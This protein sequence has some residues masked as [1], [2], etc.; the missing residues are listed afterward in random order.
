MA[1]W[2]TGANTT[3]LSRN[4]IWV[5]HKIINDFRKFNITASAMYAV[6]PF[7]ILNIVWEIFYWNCC[8]VGVFL[9]WQSTYCVCLFL[10]CFCFFFVNQKSIQD[11]HHRKKS[12]KSDPIGKCTQWFFS[13]RLQ[14]VHEIQYSCHRMTFVFNISCS[15][16][17]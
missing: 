12:L 6:W 2:I 17:T 7:E 10:V 1:S 5:I 9:V 8:F 15:G 14:F 13:Q 4:V 16:A 11:D 3:M